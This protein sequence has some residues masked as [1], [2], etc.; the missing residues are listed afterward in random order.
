M[1][2]PPPY[3]ASNIEPIS[4]VYLSH[5]IYAFNLHFRG[6]RYLHVAGP[7][8]ETS[9]GKDTNGGPPEKRIETRDV[10][11]NIAFFRR[12]QLEIVRSG[13]HRSCL[14]PNNAKTRAY[15]IYKKSIKFVW[16]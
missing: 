13:G 14:Y 6:I 12:M 16:F 2:T 1:S 7:F 4:C 10:A 5:Y 8:S 11:E 9:R 3:P 15:K